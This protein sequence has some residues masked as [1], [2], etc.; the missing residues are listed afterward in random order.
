LVDGGRSIEDIVW[1]TYILEC[2]DG[3]YYVGSTGDVSARVELHLSGKGP[4]Y[5]AA[6]LPVRLVYS[7]QQPTL[8]SAVK[9]ERQLKRWTHAKKHALISGNF[10]QLHDL[11]RC[12]QSST[13]NTVP[14]QS[15]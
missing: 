5:T 13:I 7:E 12:R 4:G 1:Y 15:R 10:T 2:A 14:I 9:R 11:S 6:R 3:S 8:E